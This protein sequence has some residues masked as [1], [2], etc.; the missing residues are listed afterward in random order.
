M[1]RGKYYKFCAECG[2][3]MIGE[4]QRLANHCRGYHAGENNGFLKFDEFPPFP[5]YPDFKKYL[6][7]HTYTL[8]ADSLLR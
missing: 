7:G 8:V 3:K 2:L 1:R 4:A 5:I 6:M